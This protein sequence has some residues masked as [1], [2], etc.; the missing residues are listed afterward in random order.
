MA[1]LSAQALCRMVGK[2]PNDT[3]GNSFR[4]IERYAKKLDIPPHSACLRVMTDTEKV[5]KLI[6][7]GENNEA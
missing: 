6:L 4:Y 5:L 7:K 1:E 3:L 2:Q